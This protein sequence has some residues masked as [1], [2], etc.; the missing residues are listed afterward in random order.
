MAVYK[1]MQGFSTP[2]APFVETVV[3]NPKLNLVDQ[4]REVIALETA[5]P[6]ISPSPSN[7]AA[8]G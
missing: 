7:L 6:L 4:V 8:P 3:P 5:E 1:I 2:P